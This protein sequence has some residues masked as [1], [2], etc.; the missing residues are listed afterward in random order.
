MAQKNNNWM[1]PKVTRSLPGTPFKKRQF[2]L[3]ISTHQEEEFQER[4]SDEEDE[5]SIES[6]EEF[7]V[8][9][10]DEPYFHNE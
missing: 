2:K 1:I 3:T 7:T 10:D 4:W 8:D 6:E 5:L 9:S